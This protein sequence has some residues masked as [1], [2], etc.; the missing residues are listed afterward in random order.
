MTRSARR[1]P[2]VA[3]SATVALKIFQAVAFVGGQARTPAL[4]AFGLAH[5]SPQRFHRAAQ[6]LGHRSNRRPLRRVF[7]R[8]FLNEP[9]RAFTQLR[10]V[11]AGSCHGLHP[12]SEWAL[13]Q[14]RYGSVVKAASGTNVT[15]QAL[16]HTVGTVIVAMAAVP[17]TW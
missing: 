8:M 3:T 6:F 9:D 16:T 12:L 17:L 14:T 5:P 2:A 10:G 13:R 7:V 15:C 4:V 1:F 11:L